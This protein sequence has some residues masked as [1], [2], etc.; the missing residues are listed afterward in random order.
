MNRRIALIYSIAS[1][2]VLILTVGCGG[3]KKNPFSVKSEVV[4]AADR[5]ITLAFAPDGRLFYGEHQTGNIRIVSS[6]GKLLQEPFAHVDTQIGLEWGLTGLAFDPKFDQNH[7]VYVY[8]TQLV[9]P[10]PPTSVTA[11]PIVTRFTE[12]D[13]KGVDPAV[14][15]GDLPET[16]PKHPGY[17]A[18][19]RIGFGSDGFLYITVGDYDIGNSS[20]LATPQGKILRVN[21]LD[22]SA[23]TDNPFVGQPNVDPRIFAYGF[24]EPF[25]F[26]VHPQNRKIYG[27]DNTPVSCE[28][29]NIIDR[30]GNYGFPNVGPF[31]YADCQF[32][33]HIKGI[34][35]FSKKGT[36]P[37]DFLSNTYVSGV[38]FVDGA[39]YPTI[40]AA[41]L[42]CES[43]MDTHDLRRLTLSDTGTQVL[44][45]DIVI[46]DCNMDVKVSPDGTIFY[47]N[48]KEIRRL[49]F[50]ATSKD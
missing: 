33:E 39:K 42:V 13:N 41:L 10:G 32:G 21:K 29:L 34:H 25:D 37:E 18:N 47:S 40:G 35:F 26:A 6:D 22:G 19:G 8:F 43:E 49:V 4:T 12:R 48:E 7:Y 44:A 2:I 20:D 14:I 27:T 36:R 3:D 23:V 50:E 1:L 38:A 31:P 16:D 28:E 24:R 11:R 17:N 15:V 5:P 9:N 30:G 46:D 45:D